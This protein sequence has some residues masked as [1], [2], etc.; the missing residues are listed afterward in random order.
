MSDGTNDFRSD[1]EFSDAVENKNVGKFFIRHRYLSQYMF[2]DRFGDTQWG[3]DVKGATVFETREA[4]SLALAN[5]E[6]DHA[7]DYAVFL[8]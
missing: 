7:A 8:I 6:S 2:V 4:A 3:A 5:C 1:I